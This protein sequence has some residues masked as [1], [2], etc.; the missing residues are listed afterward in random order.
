[1]FININMGCNVLV[2]VFHLSLEVL[3]ASPKYEENCAI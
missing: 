2:R 1:M 3:D